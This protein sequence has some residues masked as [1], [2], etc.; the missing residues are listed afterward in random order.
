MKKDTKI[1]V[2]V[3]VMFAAAFAIAVRENFRAGRVSDES[4]NYNIT[5]ENDLVI[6]TSKVDEPKGLPRLVELGADR[7]GPCRVMARIIAELK[8]E[9]AGV[10]NVAFID[11]WKNQDVARKLEISVIP[12]QIFLDA[13]GKELYRHT[14]IYSPKGILAKWKELG[15]DVDSAGPKSAETKQE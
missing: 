14:G 1:I 5:V 10:F 4:S 11:V 3:V 9:Y 12:T 15:V 6:V 8:Q 2:L 13:S 7:C